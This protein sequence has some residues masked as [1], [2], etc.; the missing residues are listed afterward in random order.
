[1]SHFAEIGLYIIINNEFIVIYWLVAYMCWRLV[2]VVSRA[3]LPLVSLRC[4]AGTSRLGSLP[5]SRG[6]SFNSGIP[7]RRP[8][9]RT[10]PIRRLI[11]IFGSCPFTAAVPHVTR[12]LCVYWPCVRGCTRAVYVVC[13]LTVSLPCIVLTPGGLSLHTATCQ[14]TYLSPER[15]VGVVV[16]ALSCSLWS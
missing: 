4:Q 14:T 5:G 1:M 11:R 9:R 10:C 6:Q 12:S 8:V 3:V 15:P 2:L 16:L 7:R 13:T